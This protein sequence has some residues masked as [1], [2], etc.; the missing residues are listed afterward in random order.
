MSGTMLHILT[1]LLLAALAIVCTSIVWL[2]VKG[3]RSKVTFSFVGGQFSLLLWII[4]Q[5]VIILSES[6]RQLLIG[7]DIGNLGISFIGSCW[8]LFAVSYMD[9]ELS[10]PLLCGTLG[11]SSLIFLGAVTNPLHGL[12]YSE[13]SMDGVTHG[14]LF[15][16]SQIYI[17]LAM[18]CGIALI[19]RQCFENKQRS[20][21][22]AV[23]LTLATAIPLS[24]NLL[25]L[26]NVIALDFALTPL[27]LAISD[28]LVLFA[29]YRYGFLNV[30]DVA[31]EDA[32][33]TIEEGVIVFSRRGRITY[34]SS[35]AKRMLG[36]S[37]KNDLSS[38][39]GCV[40]ELSEKP[41][42]ENFDYAEIEK[43][44]LHLGIKHYHCRDDK[45]MIVAGLVIVSD[46]SRYYQLIEKTGE[47]AGA[48][49]KLAIERERNRI[50]QEVHDTAGHTFTMISSLAKLSKVRLSDMPD[51]P[52][53]REL[54]SF[55]DET[56]SLARGGLTQ[57]RCSINNL[58][59][60]SFLT[61]VTAAVKTVTDAV[62]DIKT[63]LCI[64]G[65][66]DG[67]YAFCVQDIYSSFREL[68]TNSVRYSGADRIDVIVKFL[69][70]SVE[71]YV[72]DNGR[73]CAEITAHNGLNGIISRT[74][75]LGGTAVF[76]SGEGIGFSA[77]IKIPVPPDTKGANT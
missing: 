12:Y 56:E 58:R 30:N 40:S 35:A 21:G 33:N 45:G 73:G 76:K 22:Q 43:D 49:Q 25:T 50:A 47:L 68:I 13:F 11:F 51:S 60:D 16:V 53:L 64:Q 54:I 42:T 41:L 52:Q 65:T 27:S 69:D 71:L 2:M 15:Y 46:I 59:E 28:I 61:T 67:R 44:G 70:E 66:E 4:S 26:A 31:F 6:E 48:R 34:L 57:L 23:L 72:F 10:K 63:E 3:S 8:L 39:V 55:M 18:L 29:T 62:R 36:I 5:L 17:Y 14:P 75:K 32:F 74:E 9:R 7:Y 77:V 19:C 1:A 38:F 24:I 20:R 37:E